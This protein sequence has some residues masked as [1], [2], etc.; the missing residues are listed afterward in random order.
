PWPKAAVWLTVWTTLGLFEATQCYFAYARGN[1]PIHWSQALGMG[2]GL[3]YGWGVVAELVF[4]FARRFP[5][6]PDNWP[7][8]LPLHLAAA[9]AVTLLK[10]SLDYPV[11]KAFYCPEP[12]KLS[13][14]AFYR[15]AFVGHF[16]SYF[17]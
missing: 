2:L 4:P 6:R 8:R 13:F 16:H 12:A 5:F 17:L 10:L 14:T 11:I 9:V 1:D 3:W 7:A 15:M